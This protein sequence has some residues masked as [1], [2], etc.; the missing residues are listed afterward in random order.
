[1]FPCNPEIETGSAELGISRSM[2]DP[3]S[4]QDEVESLRNPYTHTLARKHTHTHTH[5][6]TKESWAGKMAQWVKV[7]STKP[8][9]SSVL[10]PHMVEGE[11]QLLKV[12]L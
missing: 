8:D 11:N 4:K 3:A 10:R 9:L 7:F 1:M 12:V 5:L 6:N 2:R